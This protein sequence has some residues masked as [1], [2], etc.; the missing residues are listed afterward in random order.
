VALI[1]R[2]EAAFNTLASRVFILVYV[3]D[4]N[5][6]PVTGLI[7]GN[8]RVSSHDPLDVLNPDDWWSLDLADYFPEFA[9][10]YTLSLPPLTYARG[11]QQAYLVRVARIP[12]GTIDIKQLEAARGE[13]VA[14]PK[15]DSSAR[16]A[17][18]RHSG[19]DEGFALAHLVY[20]GS[21]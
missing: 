18:T 6:V 9:G 4:E 13:M 2:A 11:G 15:R 16:K 14:R 21:V 19:K 20:F 12:S 10:F 7:E 3:G 17:E 5:G 8:F 1:V